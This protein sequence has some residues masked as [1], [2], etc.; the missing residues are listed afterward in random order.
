MPRLASVK[1]PLTEAQQ[2]RIRDASGQTVTEIVVTGQT[3]KNE[4]HSGESPSAID[5]MVA[6]MVA[7]KIEKLKK[8]DQSGK[9]AEPLIAIVR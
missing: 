4:A 5:R 8:A 6:T 9:Y 1:V 3:T 2:K 7:G